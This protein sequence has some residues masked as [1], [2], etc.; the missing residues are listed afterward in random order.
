MIAAVR[1]TSASS[2]SGTPAPRSDNARRLS[3]AK[4]T[5]DPYC[6]TLRS[7]GERCR[8]NAQHL[9]DVVGGD[10]TGA[11]D[12]RG[13]AGEVD[14]RRRRLLFGRPPVE[15]DLYKVAELTPGV[16]GGHRGWATGDVG[17]GDR[18]R[19]DLSQ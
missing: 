13:G 4:T 19:A 11:K 18:H 9:G 1:P 16:V 6:T 7:S 8:V 3:A 15:V 12:A 10:W 17:A 5:G 2:R 14:D